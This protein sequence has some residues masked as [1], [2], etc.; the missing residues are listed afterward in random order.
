M[1]YPGLKVCIDWYLARSEETE[2]W[3]RTRKEN[4][5][6]QGSESYSTTSQ[7]ATGTTTGHMREDLALG[8]STG[9]PAIWTP[10][11][12][13]PPSRRATDMFVLF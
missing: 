6:T 7:G 4:H 2:V 9:Y 12:L 13:L 3:M 8:A 5:E 11:F 10:D 1:Y